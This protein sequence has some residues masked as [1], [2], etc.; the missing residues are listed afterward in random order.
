MGAMKNLLHDEV[1]FDAYQR[2]RL[3]EDQEHHRVSE[4]EAEL[5]A[6]KE[7]CDAFWLAYTEERE[8]LEEAR[9]EI[10]KLHSQ[11]RAF[12]QLAQ[13]EINEGDF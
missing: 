1:A 10:V 12:R 3:I 2:A 13:A 6:T 4:L 11:L 9:A 5:S 7:D 8:A